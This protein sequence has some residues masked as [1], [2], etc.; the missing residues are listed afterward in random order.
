MATDATGTPSTNF[1]FPKYNVNVDPP[2]GLGFN[3]FVDDLD[4]KLNS[5]FVHSADTQATNEVPVWNGSA[6]IYQK[7]TPSQM[8][9]ASARQFVGSDDS[10]NPTWVTGGWY[11]IQ[12]S[13]LAAGQASIDINSIPQTFTALEAKIWWRAAAGSGGQTI[14]VRINGD[15]G[16]NYG[17]ATVG[18]SSGATFAAENATTSGWRVGYGEAAGT[19][20]QYS[21]ATLRLA[22]YTKAE[23]HSFESTF[24]GYSGAS[25]VSGMVGG[26]Y[27][28]TRAAI[29]ALSFFVEGGTLNLDTGTVIAL[30]GIG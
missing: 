27:F 23:R 25:N 18:V 7:V 13:T 4:S 6:W 8:S 17:W 24:G 10:G 5:Q 28:G 19:D 3:A 16:N 30:Y 26:R 29:T 9:G 21:N 12:K 14:A 15:S 1:S 22:G 11:L 2:S 20:E